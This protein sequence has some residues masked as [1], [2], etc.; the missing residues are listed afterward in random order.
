M[1]QVRRIGQ[2]TLL[3]LCILQTN[4]SA[5]QETLIAGAKKE[6][7]FLWYAS[8]VVIESRRLLDAFEKKY[9]FLKTEVYRASSDKI[10]NKISLEARTGQ[11]FFDAVAIEDI[12]FG[13]L[14]KMAFISPYESPERRA[15]LER[16]KD[17]N[18]YWTDTYNNWYSI[19]YNTRQV[20]REEA[21][22]NWE[23]LLL[24]KWRGKI[25]LPDTAEIW[26]GNLMRAMG[27]KRGRE[28]MQRLAANRLEVRR[29]FTH[30]AELMTAGEFPLAIVRPH[31]VEKSK[32]AGAPIDWVRSVD[33]I[34]ADMHPIGLSAK[35][36]HPNAAKLFIDYILSKEGQ[37]V[38]VQLGRIS[39]RPDM[40]PPYPALK[41]DG[42]NIVPTDPSLSE[43][44]DKI[45]EEFRRLFE[46]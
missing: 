20:R 40:D 36:P 6:G 13:L 41:R 3:C 29:G 4:A 12:E 11:H 34:L 14:P 19:G 31:R 15:Y 46:Q 2:I 30:T 9:P 5:Q 21:P 26:Y 42:L 8:M 27:E 37:G 22:K 23:D 7:K 18:G 32:A 38:M 44:F 28:F 39:P 16:F 33:P 24:P 45:Q 25:G 43:T 1:K 10:L 17:K 35:P